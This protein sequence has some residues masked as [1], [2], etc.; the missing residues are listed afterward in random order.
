MAA[1]LAASLHQRYRR[2]TTLLDYSPTTSTTL[3]HHRCMHLYQHRVVSDNCVYCLQ[4]MQDTVTLSRC[5]LSLSAACQRAAVVLSVDGFLSARTHGWPRRRHARYQRNHTRGATEQLGGA[6]SHVARS[7]GGVGIVWD[8]AIYNFPFGIL[9][10]WTRRRRA[11][12]V[13]GTGTP[14]FGHL[15]L[16]VWCLLAVSAG[17]G[18]P[19]NRLLVSNRLGTGWRWFESI[20]ARRAHLR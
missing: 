8:G 1:R 19:T 13:P 10:L 2:H 7:F 18:L 11:I 5:L 14:Y 3:H 6:I 4:E 9:A 20:A 12:P 17:A 15:L 16:P